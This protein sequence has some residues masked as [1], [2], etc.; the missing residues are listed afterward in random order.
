MG[1]KICDEYLSSVE[2]DKSSRARIVQ[3]VQSHSKHGFYGDTSLE[4]RVVSDADLLDEI[5]AI[6]VLWDAMACA[7][8]DAPSYEKA[9]DRIKKAYTKL[10]IELPDRLHT[11]TARQILEERL[12]FLNTLE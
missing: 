12:S 11:V 3:I 4:A 10:K 9:T 6:T 1:A 2:Y 8:E 5:G 7:G